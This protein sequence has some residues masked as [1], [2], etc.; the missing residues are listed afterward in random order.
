MGAAFRCC[1]GWAKGAALAAA[2]VVCGSVS[3]TDSGWRT[4]SAPSY[5]QPLIDAKL[6]AYH[7]AFPDIRFVYLRGGRF[8]EQDYPKL[9]RLLSSGARSLDYEHPPELAQPLLTLAVQRVELMLRQSGTSATLF[10]LAEHAESRRP[11]LC[12]LT[13]DSET[14][15]LDD[16]QATRHLLDISDRH[17]AA[18]PASRYLD[19]REHLAFVIDHEMYQCLD[20]YYNGPM[21]MSDREHAA[22]YAAFRNENGADAFAIAMRLQDRGPGRYVQNLIRIRALSLLQQDPEHFTDGSMRSMVQTYPG[23]IVGQPMQKLF[24]SA[25]RIRDQQVPDYDGYLAFAAAALR[26]GEELG[27]EA[28]QPGLQPY[29]DIEPDA[30][31]LG[32]LTFRVLSSYRQLFARGD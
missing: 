1:R 32:T 13:L 28:A 25:T 14:V 15:A 10:G 27:G 23:G 31:M 24:E 12:V 30:A 18:I 5:L 11:A 22:S 21:P 3:A 9:E 17:F 6:L 26:A 2:W 7:R 29:G 19:H 20:S 4:P 16:V 8:A